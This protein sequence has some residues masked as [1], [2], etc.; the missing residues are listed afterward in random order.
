MEGFDMDANNPS[1]ASRRTTNAF[2]TLRKFAALRAPEAPTGPAAFG[3]AP[4]HCEL[5]SIA[6]A[7]EHRHLLETGK[8]HIA[9]AC[10][11]CALRFSDV[12]D[13]RFQ[14]IPRD[15][16][17]LP[18]FRLSDGEWEALS[19]PIDLA[20][21]FRHGPDGKIVALYPSPAGAT[22]SLLSLE[23]WETLV[24]ENPA[25]RELQPDVEA[26][27][28]NRAGE[29]RV[30]YIVPIDLCFELVGLIR[31]HWSGLSG[32]EEVWREI[33]GFFVRLEERSRPW[34]QQEGVHA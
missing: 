3:S 7:P 29:R 17:S 2:A 5:C 31:L 21:F 24:G 30:Y 10:D 6:L 8:R 14:L 1:Q 13:G 4:E 19:L 23:A 9:C 25:L 34:K 16:R 33:D 22:E 28:V 32:G 18:N 15:V 26:L 27:L 12:V 20:F 11:A